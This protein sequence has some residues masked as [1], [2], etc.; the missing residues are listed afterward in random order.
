MLF[1]ILFHKNL[2]KI[3][4]KKWINKCL[5]SLEDQTFQKF[6]IFEINYGN[7]DFS[8]KE[9]FSKNFLNNKKYEFVSKE[10][11]SHSHAMN[12]IINYGIN[13]KDNNYTHIGMVHMDDY[14]NKDRLKIQMHYLQKYKYDLISNNIQYI[15][16]NGSFD[17]KI[18]LH[19]KNCKTDD[20]WIDK[21]FKKGNNVIAHPSVI[22]TTNFFK[23][24][25]PYP[26]TV[27]R[28]DFDLWINGRKLGM[29][30]KILE[31]FL[32]YYRIHNNQSCSKK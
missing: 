18:Y 31:D 19:N 8:L 28:E 21:N 12:F 1:L 23:K 6:D 2:Y 14:Y 32:L 13:S 9:K 16:H 26:H 10:L 30:M 22:F 4:K 17:K 7:D 5:K 24:V 11:K 15:N 29:K 3:Y 27:P 25:G 20:E